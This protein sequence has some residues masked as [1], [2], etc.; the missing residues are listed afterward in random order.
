V[1]RVIVS[2]VA[3]AAAAVTFVVLTPII[4][5]VGAAIV[6]S[7]VGSAIAYG[8]NAI[9]DSI[10][11][12]PQRRTLAQ[13]ASDA[14]R[15]VR[16]ASEPRRIVYGR[17]RIS[18]P[19]IY[20]SSY[21][22]QK[23]WLQLVVALADQPLQSIDAVWLGETRIPVSDIAANG[24]VTAG[25][26][27]A[28]YRK[29]TFAEKARAIA[30]GRDPLAPIL[31]GGVYIKRYLGTQTTADPDL[32]ANSPDGWTASDKLT[33]VAYL[34]VRMRFNADWFPYGIPNVS[35]EVT[36]KAQ[37][38]DPRTN[39]TAYSNNWALCVLDYL[40]AEYG[41][42]AADDEIDLA[43]FIS[44]ANLS[45]EA[46]PLN[47]A[48]TETQKRYTIDGSFTLD[49]API[50]IIER[51]LAPGGGALIYVAGKYRLYGGAYTAPAIT[52]TT[53]DLASDFEVT[54][55][56]PRRDLFNSVRGNFI[57]PARFWQ[58]SEFTPVKS[59]A[60]IAEDG[61]EIWRELELPF[62]LDSTRAQRIA[63]QLLL[64]ARQSVTFRASFRYASLDL[65]VWQVV[66]LTIPELGWA[67]KPFRI[68]AWTFSP[69]NGLIT[70]SMQEEQVSSYAWTYDEAASVPD[71]PD[72]TLISP[73]DVPAPKGLGAT[74]SLYVTRDGAG[75]RTAVALEWLEPENPFVTGYEIQM[76]PEGLEDW[77]RVAT[78]QTPPGQVLDLAAGSYD[79]R[80]RAV[81]NSSQGQWA[82]LRYSVG[83]LA[84]QPPAAVTGLNLQAIGGF[85]WLGW[86]RHPELDVRVGGRFEIRH[87]PST[88]SPTWAG[89]TSLGPALTG[90]ATFAPVPLRA[91]TYFVRAVDAGGV[92][93]AAASIQSGQATALPFANVSSVQ[94]DAGFAGTKTNVLAAAGVLKLD[95]EGNWDAAAS[96]DAIPNVDNMGLVK[97]S[98]S[99]VFAGGLDL[100]VVKPIRLTAH[101][102]ASVASFGTSWD[103]RVS[104]LDDWGAID[105]VFGGEA[106]AW[107]E[108][109]RTNDNPAGTPIWS[110]WQRLDSAEFNA[111]AF[112]FRA[113]LRSFQPEFNIEVTQLRVAAD[114]VV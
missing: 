84:A 95:T 19:L 81:T 76:S 87:T 62:V 23:E 48:G 85:A 18:G 24:L 111:R 3:A 55:K 10:E 56:P 65:S 53:S 83:G 54:T 110:G 42:A 78:P 103:Q 14:R 47:Q 112:Q 52:L 79:F 108:V 93:G 104:M 58:S 17:A 5:P 96:V 8:G 4:G 21:G 89:A 22:S 31:T 34:Y 107:V 50:S 69:E 6:A 60:L 20:A 38:L 90:E 61:E 45:D 15:I 99:Y 98:G 97:A 41:L 71:V 66:A 9:V 100:A 63:K 30:E 68:M 29:Q 25:R 57:D 92:Y 72:T 28:T 75:V 91:G 106:D 16:G 82:T 70:L 49:Q 46:V 59:A 27:A 43:S 114:E 37:I 67:A 73:F 105:D 113:Q 7:L 39:T 51:M 13:D 80:V 11:G 26:F 74:E 77:R 2:I 102:L 88:S 12:K 33:G 32:V 109:R 35:A 1:G 94:E 101:L 44:A 36:G 86:D 40:K 64:R